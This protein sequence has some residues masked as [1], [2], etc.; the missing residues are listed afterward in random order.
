MR[1]KAE[2]QT[3]IYSWCVGQKVENLRF[4]QRT[5]N[6]MFILPGKRILRVAGVG[7]VLLTGGTFEKGQTILAVRIHEGAG[8]FTIL[9]GQLPNVITCSIVFFVKTAQAQ[10]VKVFLAG[11]D[12][13]GEFDLEVA[14]Q[15]AHD[16]TWTMGQEFYSR[17]KGR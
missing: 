16:H 13:T 6:F 1:P 14:G 12:V 17:K 15:T 3:H 8:T 10:P 2:L 5:S 4:D 9:L 11:E 7:D